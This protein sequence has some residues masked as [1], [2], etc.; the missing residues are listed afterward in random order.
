[1][2]EF[3]PRTDA[4][5][6]IEIPQRDDEFY[7][8]RAWFSSSLAFITEN[9]YELYNDA[10]QTPLAQEPQVLHK[11]TNPIKIAV[12]NALN[13]P[14]ERLGWALY[15][16]DHYHNHEKDGSTMLA[17]SAEGELISI[18]RSHMHNGRSNS[19]ATFSDG[20]SIYITDYKKAENVLNKIIGRMNHI[21]RKPLIV[22]INRSR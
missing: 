4:K 19:Q 22:A 8:S 7:A 20:S 17:I 11:E 1:M 18:H 13:R 9:F 3:I 14:N 6:F 15:E 5:E 21:L 10:E 12:N 16:H 2:A